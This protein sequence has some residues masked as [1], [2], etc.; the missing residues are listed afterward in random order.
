MTLESLDSDAGVAYAGGGWQTEGLKT[1]PNADTVLADTGELT[2][3][4]Y[5]FMLF[6]NVN[7]AATQTF[8]VQYRN[9]ANNATLK[10]QILGIGANDTLL[11]CIG[12]LYV[13]EAERYRI[14]VR[15]N[16]TGKAQAS[17]IYTQRA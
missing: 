6:L 9:A 11:F 8:A 3:G 17:V 7:T 1:N 16:Y 12:G 2:E 5:D 15:A 14:I 10:E 4:I 13:N